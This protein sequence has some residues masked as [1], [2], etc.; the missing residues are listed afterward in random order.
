MRHDDIHCRQL[1][2]WQL[3]DGVTTALVVHHA[4]LTGPSGVAKLHSRLEAAGGDKQ[5]AGVC[6]VTVASLGRLGN[7][8]TRHRIICFGSSSP[9]HWLGP[10]GE[11]G[12]G[13][14]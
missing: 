4:V 8:F 11:G 1:E 13:G 12:G 5:A 10:G 3:R 2:P 6:Q 9:T 7:L 14:V